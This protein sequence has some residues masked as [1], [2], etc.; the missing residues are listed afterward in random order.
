MKTQIFDIV[1]NEK[2]EEIIEAAA[3]I[4]N[5]G[6]TVAFPTETVYGIGANALDRNAIG[7]IFEAKGRPSD[8][9]LI[10]H[11]S[12]V[13]ELEKLVLKINE[14]AQPL[15]DKFWPGP[16]TIIFEKNN[17]VPDSVTAG[18]PTVAV[19]MPKDEIALKLIR[20]AGCPI[21][22][23]S[24]NLS[25]KP[26]PT[27]AEHVVD[28]LNGRVDAIIKGKDCAVGIESTVIDLST[29]KAT[30]LRPGI[31]TKEEIEA[32]IGNTDNDKGLMTEKEVPKSPGMKYKH[33]APKAPVTIFEGDLKQVIEEIKRLKKCHED[34]GLKVGIIASDETKACYSGYVHSL[35]SRRDPKQIAKLLFDTLRN[36]DNENVDVILA[37]SFDREGVG[38]AVMNRMIKSAGH[39]IIKVGRERP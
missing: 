3:K 21:A 9:P 11:I 31:I 33:Y 30:I 38:F 28:D 10:I 29:D 12:D 19:R 27:K 36:F 16:L 32:V 13:K 17:I 37:E 4:I 6:G 14:K 8:N 20:K 34:K 39:N 22:A 15:I 18:L 1:D 23:P 35:G 25:G 5:E 2:T 26:S 7:K 24:A